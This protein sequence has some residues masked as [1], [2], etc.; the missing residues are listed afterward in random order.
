MRKSLAPQHIAQAMN[1]FGVAV[2]IRE[3]HFSSLAP[4]VLEDFGC[5]RLK[6][7]NMDP[8]SE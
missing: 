7:E 1:G 5:S 8:A 2:K 4:E 6:G 3:A